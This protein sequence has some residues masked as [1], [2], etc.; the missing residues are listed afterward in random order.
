MTSSIFSFDAARPRG[1]R[2]AIVASARELLLAVVS[3]LVVLLA[4]EGMLRGF[5][6]FG[7]NG[8]NQIRARFS[9]PDHEL[10]VGRP[11]YKREFANPVYRNAEG[12]HARPF[13][14][15]PERPV[16][17]AVIGDSYLE[18]HQLPVD[19][20]FSSVAQRSLPG[21]QIVALGASAQYAPRQMS[22]F[23]D[24][25]LSLFGEDGNYPG[26]DAVVFCLRLNGLRNVAQ[27]DARY[28]VSMPP[29]T[30]K[31]RW[32]E[33]I[34]ARAQLVAVRMINAPSHALSWAGSRTLDAMRADLRNTLPPVDSERIEFADRVLREEVFGEILRLAEE[35]GV[36][37]GFVYLP[38]VNEYQHRASELE[39]EFR[40]RVHAMFDDLGVTWV[41]AL[42]GMPPGQEMFFPYD[43]HATQ[44]GHEYFGRALVEVIE[45]MA[46]GTGSN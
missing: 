25:F 20:H 22:L 11:W 43:R 10:I 44:L 13:G 40:D 38:R 16:R 24:E 28:S 39:L 30:S 23:R 7:Y 6:D 3:L 2:E 45:K 34:Q 46:V 5:D 41:N 29:L 1:A 9:Q 26:V 36:K 4:V 12:Y 8:P 19:L 33:K 18:A 35:R 31:Y 37:V 15:D 32:K 21:I 42:D 17:V 14:A 27:G